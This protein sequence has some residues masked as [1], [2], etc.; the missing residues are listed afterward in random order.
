MAGGGGGGGGGRVTVKKI[1]M[2]TDD[3]RRT[4]SKLKLT[5]CGITLEI[6]DQHY[7]KLRSAPV[8]N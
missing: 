1:D 6:N 7:E 5:C 2:S 3:G 4:R 8:L